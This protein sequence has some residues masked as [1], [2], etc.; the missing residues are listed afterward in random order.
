MHASQL[1]GLKS[2]SIYMIQLRGCG[3]LCRCCLQLPAS[4]AAVLRSVLEHQPNDLRAVDGNRNPVLLLLLAMPAAQ[5]IAPADY[6]SVMMVPL[7]KADRCHLKLLC[8]QPAAEALEAEHVCKLLGVLLQHRVVDSSSSTWR[9]GADL[10]LGLTAAG[11]MGS[12]Q[13]EDLLQ[14]VR[15][16]PCDR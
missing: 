14:H 12:E 9:P 3:C 11:E 13:I 10:L 15:F 7:L 8:E 2:A 16:C 5:H 1:L 4:V 6:V